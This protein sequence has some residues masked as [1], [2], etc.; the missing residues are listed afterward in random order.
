MP[1]PRAYSNHSYEHAHHTR[2]C[3]CVYARS[4]CACA[5]TCDRARK[6]VRRLTRC[7]CTRTAQAHTR[8]VC[9]SRRL[10]Y[11]SVAYAA[12]AS[13]RTRCLQRSCAPNTTCCIYA[14]FCAPCCVAAQQREIAKMWRNISTQSCDMRSLASALWRLSPHNSHS[15]HSILIYNTTDCSLN[16]MSHTRDTPHK[17]SCAGCW[18]LSY[19]VIARRQ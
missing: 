19:A 10:V 12:H 1:R 9:A 2:V 13:T 5:A 17:R 7:T 15:S 11:P 18:R 16:A 14:L 4:M 3:M 6:H 8:P